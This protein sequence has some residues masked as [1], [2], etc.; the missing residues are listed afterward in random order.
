MIITREQFE[1]Y[2]EVRASGVTNMFSV[3][4]VQELSGLSRPEIIE[5][6]EHYS[7]LMEQYP[8]VRK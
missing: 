4:T 1:A 6:M 7:E 2:E 8:D 5:I 3:L